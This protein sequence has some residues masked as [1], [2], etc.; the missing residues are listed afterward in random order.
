MDYTLKSSPLICLRT[1]CV[2]RMLPSSTTEPADL[3]PF[4]SSRGHKVIPLQTAVVHPTGSM[5]AVGNDNQ[6]DVAAA[7]YFHYG[8]N[9]ALKSPSH[10]CETT[11]SR[12][13]TYFWK[14]LQLKVELFKDLQDQ[15]V[16]V[17]RVNHCLLARNLTVWLSC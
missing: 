3:V 14:L 7:W 6:L 1:D 17:I 8:E 5:K 15:Q 12:L 4:A 16:R 13:I 11:C 2:P 10:F 9:T